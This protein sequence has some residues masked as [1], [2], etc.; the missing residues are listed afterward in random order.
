ME[1]LVSFNKLKSFLSRNLQFLYNKLGEITLTAGTKTSKNT[2]TSRIFKE[3]ING[4]TYYGFYS[5]M[6]QLQTQIKIKSQ[7]DTNFTYIIK[8]FLYQNNTD[9]TPTKI[10]DII[11]T[12]PIPEYGFTL[13][14]EFYENKKSYNQ[15]YQRLYILCSCDKQSDF[16]GIIRIS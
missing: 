6:F 11:T 1:Q 2:F 16:P 3:T 8:S 15:Y 4:N 10:K 7:T 13:S 14:P 5:N 12:A 9:N